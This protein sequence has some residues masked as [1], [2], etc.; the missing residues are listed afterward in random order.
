MEKFEY[1]YEAGEQ[2]VILAGSGDLMDMVTHI[3]RQAQIINTRL[4]SR[5]AEAAASFRAALGVLF[6]D[7]S[8]PAW[9][10]G[11]EVRQGI[12][13]FS[14]TREKS[15][16]G[17]IGM[18]TLR[19]EPGKPWE[20]VEVP[21]ELEALQ[22]AVGG[23]LERVT[24]ASDICVLC[25]KEAMCKGLPHNT[26]ICGTVEFFGTVLIVGMANGEFVSLSEQQV[27]DLWEMGALRRGDL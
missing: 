10:D 23:H 2:G 14:V 20:I 1:K 5:N 22:K 16:G 8:S 19:K 15:R 13:F 3:T 7:P 17:G 4:R 12:D 26:D 27:E 24:F 18:R 21:N 6:M 9:E 25:D 11:P